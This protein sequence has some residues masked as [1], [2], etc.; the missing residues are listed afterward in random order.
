M[1]S[2]KNAIALIINFEGWDVPWEWP[3]GSSGV[4]IPYGYD[5]GYEPFEKDWAG[6][7]AGRDYSRLAKVVGLKGRAARDVTPSLHGIH[8]SRDEA[9]H[10]FDAIT[11]PRYELL[12]AST[13]PG[14]EK[15]PPDAFG[16][17]VSLVYNRGAGMKDRPGCISRAEMR[18]IRDLLN[19][20]EKPTSGFLRKLAELVRVQ[21]RYWPEHGRESDSD[22]Y[23]RRLDEGALIESCI[24]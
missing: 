8:V 16:A 13:F 15:L 19:G 11:L 12:V 18:D 4:T 1:H 24:S 10:V 7:L 20:M 3:G 22:L 5:L 9:N 14:S 2:G 17:L 6:L 21:A 23:H